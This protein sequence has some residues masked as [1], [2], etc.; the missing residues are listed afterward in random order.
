MKK[1]LLLF[2]ILIGFQV[3]TAQSLTE[4][5][6]AADAATLKTNTHV[7]IKDVVRQVIQKIND[8]NKP[9]IYLNFG[10]N[11]PQNSFTLIINEEDFKKFP[12][13]N[14]WRNKFV[15]VEGITSTYQY[16]YK[17][18]YFT[19]PCIILTNSDLLR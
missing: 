19:A 11:W 3:C 18:E 10:E 13:V 1:T 14:K 17:E 16:F 9:V 7:V 15:E 5:I 2:A 6:E 4:G 12:D 8:K